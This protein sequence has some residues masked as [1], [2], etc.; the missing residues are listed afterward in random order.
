[1][2]TALAFSGGKDSWACLWL[3]KDMLADIIV[4]WVNTGKNYPELLETIEKAKAICPNFIELIVDRDGQNAHN[5]LPSDI[6]PVN[7]TV[8]GQIVTKIKT[9]TIQS[10]IQCCYEN[11]AHNLQK[12]CLDNGIT[13]LIRGQRSDEGHKSSARSDDVVNGIK[14]IQPIEYWSELD[15]MDYLRQHMEIPNHFH[16]KHSSMDCFDCTAYVPES[17]DRI[18][19]M[20]HNHPNLYAQYAER[21]KALDD[22]VYESIKEYSN[23]AT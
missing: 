9:V 3:N 13:H 8:T 6:V 19:Y 17:I 14:Y 5:G 2:K 18:K 20:K 15:V 1:M 11:I 12:W 23:G 7:W 4:V 16:L 21:K 10:Y 22:A